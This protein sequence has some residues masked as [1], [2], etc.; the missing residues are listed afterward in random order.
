MLF[1]DSSGDCSW[2]DGR[3]ALASKF[4]I[5]IIFMVRGDKGK[6]RITQQ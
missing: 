1:E 6:V 5:L 3:V 4:E 2:W